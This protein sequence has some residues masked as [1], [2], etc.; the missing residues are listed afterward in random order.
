MIF[1]KNG[2]PMAFPASG[3]YLA[4][5]AAKF[6][7]LVPSSTLQNHCSPPK[8]TQMNRNPGEATPKG[9]LEPGGGGSPGQ[10]GQRQ[11]QVVKMSASN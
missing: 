11:V 7:K 4:R 9:L 10:P 3:T 2:L 1:F 6:Y 8:I 5:T